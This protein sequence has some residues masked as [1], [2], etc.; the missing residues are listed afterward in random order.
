METEA[1][2]IIKLWKLSQ[3]NL[4]NYSAPAMEIPYLNKAQ[5]ILQ[6]LHLQQKFALSSHWKTGLSPRTKVHAL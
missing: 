3:Q 6:I 2:I 5:S 1:P 4:K